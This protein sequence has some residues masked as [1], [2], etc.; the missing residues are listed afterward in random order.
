MRFSKL[1]VITLVVLA[2]NISV[3]LYSIY[4]SW[5]V[6]AVGQIEV[7]YQLPNAQRAKEV[8]DVTIENGMMRSFSRFPDQPNVGFYCNMHFLKVPFKSL[9][10]AYYSSCD[11]SDASPSPDIDQEHWFSNLGY[12]HSSDMFALYQYKTYPDKDKIL[13]IRLSPNNQA[14]IFHLATG[15]AID[16]LR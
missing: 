12:L 11:L 1:T 5:T 2:M 9:L 3:L 4:R 8:Q 14:A 16:A 6:Q 10:F 13:L 15:N 7:Q